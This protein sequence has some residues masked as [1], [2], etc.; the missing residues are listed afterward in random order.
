MP[1]TKDVEV[2]YL[3]ARLEK[4]ETGPGGRL[5]SDELNLDWVNSI[6]VKRARIT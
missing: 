4:V 3:L 5:S 1:L 2:A 6:A